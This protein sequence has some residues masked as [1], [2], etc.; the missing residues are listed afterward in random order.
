MELI[1]LS[2]TGILALLVAELADLVAREPFDRPA[3]AA[4]VVRVLTC[5]IV[6]VTVAGATPVTPDNRLDRAA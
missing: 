4:G 6:P 2:T 5:P 3:G 1:M